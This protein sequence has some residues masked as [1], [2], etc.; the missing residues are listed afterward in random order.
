MTYEEIL[1]KFSAFSKSKVKLCA[2]N[3]SMENL[4]Q[5]KL[6]IAERRIDLFA[7]TEELSVESLRYLNV[8]AKALAFGEQLG[9]SETTK[10]YESLDEQQK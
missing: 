7:Q 10:D 5:N 1:L 8:A 9:N 6:E 2:I 3:S 4:E